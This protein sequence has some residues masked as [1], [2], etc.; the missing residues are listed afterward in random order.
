MMED[1][2]QPMWR[3]L[4][5]KGE[6]VLICDRGKDEVSFCLSPRSDGEQGQEGSMAT[7]L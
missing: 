4:T 5:G 3:V 2:V 7:L 1:E 6:D